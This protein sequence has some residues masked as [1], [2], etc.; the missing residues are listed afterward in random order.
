MLKEILRDWGMP[1]DYKGLEA[2]YI[3]QLQIMLTVIVNT[4]W[5]LSQ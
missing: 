2:F 4:T 5:I 3:Q 1:N